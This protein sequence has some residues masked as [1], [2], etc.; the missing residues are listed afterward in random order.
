MGAAG[1]AAPRRRPG[2]RAARGDRAGDPD[3]QP[4][5]GRAGQHVPR[6]RRP[7]PGG[8]GAGPPG[9]T[10]GRSAGRPPPAGAAGGPTRPRRI[11]GVYTAFTTAGGPAAAAGTG[12][13]EILPAA[14]PGTAAGA[15][16]LT[17]VQ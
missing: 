1:A 15:A 13:A 6:P 10:L 3:V 4:A 2:R 16:T 9:E 12:L 8:G 7:P 14:E 5:P 11:P 17:A